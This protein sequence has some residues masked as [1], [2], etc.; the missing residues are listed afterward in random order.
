MTTDQDYDGEAILVHSEEELFEE[1]KNAGRDIS[2]SLG[3]EYIYQVIKLPYL[4]TTC[5]QT[6]LCTYDADTYSGSWR[7]GRMGSYE[8]QKNRLILTLNVFFEVSETE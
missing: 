8:K 5:H 4:D 3:R 2:L 6:R 1:P 7:T